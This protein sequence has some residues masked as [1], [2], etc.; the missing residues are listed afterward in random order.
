MLELLLATVGAFLL[1]GIVGWA[2]EEY[3][4]LMVLGGILLAAIML[5]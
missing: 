2:C 1:A 4:P 5:A 3:S